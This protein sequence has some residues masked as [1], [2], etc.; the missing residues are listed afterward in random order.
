MRIV[1][2]AHVPFEGPGSLAEWA[3]ARGHPL[4]RVEAWTGSF[5][6][7]DE[8]DLLVVL[9][10][11]MSTSDVRRHPWLEAEREYLTR[12]IDGRKPVLGIC[13][14]A[15]LLAE[16][17]GGSVHPGNEPE[18]GWYPVHLAPAG[19]T[20]PWFTGWPET[21]VA[22]HWHGDTF[23]LPAEID[24]AASSEVTP[25]QAFVAADGRVVGLQFHL[26]WTPESVGALILSSRE[27]LAA[28][29]PHV[30]TSEQLLDASEH[31]ATARALLFH[32][33]DRMEE[34]A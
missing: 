32:M 7:P 24:P 9:G 25:N 22:G 5:P 3:A 12:C 21:F 13:L 16:V 27:D 33:L 29:G 8:V 31:F 11:P 4:L 2:L 18:I 14:G 10:G 17:V 26:E 19:R 15:Q 20:S 28:P 6:S 30:A 34:L 23:E 1:C